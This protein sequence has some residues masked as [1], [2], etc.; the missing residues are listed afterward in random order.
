MHRKNP[1]FAHPEKPKPSS[2]FDQPYFGIDCAAHFSRHWRIWTG[3]GLS[4]SR[5]SLGLRLFGARFRAKGPVLILELRTLLLSGFGL[6]G[7]ASRVAVG[8][9]YASGL[10]LGQRTKRH[11]YLRA[12]IYRYVHTYVHV[13]ISAC[14]RM[15]T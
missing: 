1:G 13:C 9:V 6:W 14:L 4:G 8:W 11:A 12:Y 10:R 15:R 3:V 7:L 2:A 5:L